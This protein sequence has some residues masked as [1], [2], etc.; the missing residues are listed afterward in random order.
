MK[1]DSKVALKIEFSSIE[2]FVVD[3]AYANLKW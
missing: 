1:S 3:L 2:T